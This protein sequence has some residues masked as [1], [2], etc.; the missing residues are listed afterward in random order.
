MR[1]ASGQATTRRI[2]EYYLYGEARRRV[3]GRFVHVESIPT[4]SARHGWRIEPHLHR[5]MHQIVLVSAGRGVARAEGAVTHFRS[6]AL[7]L[8]PT[9]AVHGY[10]FEPGTQGLV[11]SFAE[12]L[13]LDLARREA[14]VARLFAAP[15][16]LELPG[17]SSDTAR[18]LRNAHA[19]EGA[20]DLGGP[21]GS[22]ALEGALAVLLADVMRH[23]QLLACADATQSR[24]RDLVARFR[25]VI[26]MQF[27]S[28][29]SIRQYALALHVS[30]AR[31]RNACLS[32]SGQP[33]IQ[34]L[35]ARVVLEAKRQL[36]YTGLPVRE[37]AYALGF[38]DPSYFT[39]FFNR[40]V[41]MAPRSYRTHGWRD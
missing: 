3:P 29:R 16:T 38:T 20:H 19:L 8:A 15:Q 11:I 25:G 34:L 23:A 6:P 28:N 9:G 10:E 17:D 12:E 5:W 4:R 26:E 1:T 41:G 32:V 13:L 36:V 31:L 40:R 2:P 18:L 24:N 33:P 27:R 37:V 22:L 30:E 14:A 21:T 7:I 39:R 35:H